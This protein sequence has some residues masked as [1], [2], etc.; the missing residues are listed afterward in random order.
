MFV[1]TRFGTVHRIEKGKT[2]PDFSFLFVFFLIIGLIFVIQSFWKSCFKTVIIYDYQI[3][4]FYRNGIFKKILPAGKHRYWNSGVEIFTEDTRNQHF[5]I[6]GQEVLTKDNI[7]LKLS[8]VVV[9]RVLDFLK[10]RNTS[11]QHEND[12]YLYI[13]LFLREVVAEKNIDDI[14]SD[15]ESISKSVLEKL[16]PI[17]SSFGI[18]VLQLNLRDIMLPAPLKR[19]YA[20]A[21]EARKDA[22]T[23]LEKA[24]GEQAVLRKLANFSKLIEDNP[25]LLELRTLQTFANSQN[26]HVTLGDI[27]KKDV[28]A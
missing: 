2:M 21:L 27:R 23:A 25:G 17:A 15:R 20:G 1:Y 7:S 11:S 8:M 16:T 10:T 5:A 22:E 6:S 14:L 13:Q 9:W 18:E 24:R 4:L 19:A 26:V 12:L 28:R 3:A